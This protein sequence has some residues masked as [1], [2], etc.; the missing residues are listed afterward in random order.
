MENWQ[1]ILLIVALYCAL[2][3][4][5]GVF[6]RAKGQNTLQD[7]FVGNRS[8]GAFVAFFTY[9]ATFHSSFAF[10]GAAG[11]MYSG[12]IRFFATFTSCVV[13]PL[14]IY[15]IGR[16]TW[17]LGQK[18]NYMTQGELVGDYYE[19]KALRYLVAVVSLIFL[20][21]YLQSQ[22]AA[23]GIIFETI[24]EGRMSYLV[25]CVILYAV[26]ISY[27]LLGGFKAVAWTDTI[28]GVLMI[29]MVWI[30]GGVILIRTS[31]ALSW[32]GLMQT[33]AARF[34]EKV[35]VPMEY[36]PT[37]MTSFISL[38]GISIYPPSFQRFFAVKNPK[39]LK[40]LS[41]TTPI[42]LI[43]FYVPIMMIAFSG[44]VYMPNLERADQVVPMMLT[45]YASPVLVGLV[46]AGALA[47]TMSST[48]SQLHSASSIFT[49]DLYKGMKPE[50]SDKQALFAGKAFIVVISAAALLLSQYTS[51]LITTIVTIAL[52]GCLQVLPSLIG[53]L[54]WKGA[55][56]QGALSGLVVGVIVV[57]LTQYVPA[58]QTPLGLSSGFWGLACNLIVFFAVS[59]CTQKPSDASIRKFHG[60]LEEVNR[61]CDER[62]PA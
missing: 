27:I 9:V 39:T 20:I 22:I 26:I 8:L 36:W 44:V 31:G 25:G 60:Y 43:F 14:M 38:F 2:V 12:G 41:V 7:Y 5:V 3:I 23:G 34:P 49:I 42:Y 6:T 48:D 30:A 61:K 55:S 47:A 59:R 13:S 4:C 51:A 24:T 10:I 17:Y 50:V 35:M 56:R 62:E 15:I 32:G 11:Q 53:A 18:Y 16:P 29:V 54:Y 37:Y 28:Q 1:I 58:I 46:M 21:P 45:Q 57:A 40:W 52:G 19:S 33:M